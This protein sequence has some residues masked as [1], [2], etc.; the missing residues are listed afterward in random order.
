MEDKKEERSHFL[1]G[2]CNIKEMFLE[3]VPFQFV[4]EMGHVSTCDSAIC[5]HVWSFFFS[6]FSEASSAIS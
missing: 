4:Q 1:E 5:N 6:L 3:K 2:V